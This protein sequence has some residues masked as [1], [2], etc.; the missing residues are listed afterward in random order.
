MNFDEG[1]LKSSCA[2]AL[3]MNHF[4]EEAFK[5]EIQEITV[6]ADGSLEY[7]LKDGGVKTWQRT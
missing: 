5:A 3:N 6:M 7:Y 1:I 4:D 2:E